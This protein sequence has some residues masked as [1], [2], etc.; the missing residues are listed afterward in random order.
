MIRISPACTRFRAV[1]IAACV[2]TGSAAPAFAGAKARLSADLADHLAAGSQAIRVIVHGIKG[3]RAPLMLEGF[4]LTV[5]RLASTSD[6][7]C[8]WTSSS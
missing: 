2:L 7:F 1:A 6:V 4:K 3:S 5:T 8:S